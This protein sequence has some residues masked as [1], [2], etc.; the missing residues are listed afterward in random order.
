MSY[1]SAIRAWNRLTSGRR[2]LVCLSICVYVATTFVVVA[3]ITSGIVQRS[4][5]GRSASLDELQ[6]IE[7]AQYSAIA[8]GGYSYNAMRPSNLAW[9]PMYPL[10]ARA[11][12]ITTGWP[13]T[14][15][16]LAVSHA[17]LLG[18]FMVFALYLAS[19]PPGASM[20]GT[21]TIAVY[22]LIGFGVLPGTL[23]MRLACSESLFAVC[24]IMSFYAMR[25]SWPVPM[26]A[27]IC[28]LASATRAFGVA[29]ALPF[30]IHLRGQSNSVGVFVRRLAVWGPLS[31]SGL[32]VFMLF[33]WWA[34]SDALAFAKTQAGWRLRADA[35]PVDKWLALAAW[36]PVWSVY[37]PASPE[38]WRRFSASLGPLG[39]LQFANP[40]YFAG[41]CLLVGIG[42]W[43]RWLSREEVTFA[44]VAL[45]IAYCGRGFEMC[46]NSQARFVA[47]LFPIYIVLGH[48]FDLLRPFAATLLLVAAAGQLYLYAKYFAAG[49]AFF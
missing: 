17:A 3:G 13:T 49:Y 47:S 20:P 45:L 25:R 23:F 33:Q 4:V 28:G 46:M 14:V 32:L 42:A 16:L 7:G 11:L 22:T 18:A 15:S 9:F 27:I 19:G 5:H 41:G 38:H 1:H 44:A 2:R 43:R 34:F 29:L 12:S 40:L 8:R 36:E 37:R 35:D 31:C 30:A 24:S 21:P 6:G 10:L 48:V 26:I 39:S